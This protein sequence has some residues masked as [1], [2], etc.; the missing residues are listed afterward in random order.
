MAVFKGGPSGLEP[1]PPLVNKKII[2]FQAFGVE[3]ANITFFRAVLLFLRKKL[4]FCE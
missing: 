1:P 4:R 2:F 3:R